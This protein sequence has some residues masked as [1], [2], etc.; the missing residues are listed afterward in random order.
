MAESLRK[1]VAFSQDRT[2]V[3]TDDAEVRPRL[4]DQGSPTAL[5]ERRGRI[6][7]WCP[8]VFAVHH[9]MYHKEQLLRHRRKLLRERWI[10]AWRCTP[11]R[12]PRQPWTHLM[13]AQYQHTRDPP[14]GP[15]EA[16]MAFTAE[17]RLEHDAWHEDA[18]GSSQ[19]SRQS[20]PKRGRP[21][22]YS[23]CSSRM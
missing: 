8:T 17:P 22:L 15:A 21:R 3:H 12:P 7:E 13:L 16:C 9:E 10:E 23:S 5:Q 11:R 19:S 6:Q 14:I 1:L 20:R 18:S 2:R 4:P